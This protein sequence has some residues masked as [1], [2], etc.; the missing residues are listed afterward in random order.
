VTTDSTRSIV[1]LGDYD[2]DYPREKLLRR[3]FEEAG[4]TV[5]E[6]RFSE[7]SRFIGPAKLLLL[8]LFVVRIVRRMDEIRD[9]DNEIDALVLT[10]FNPL[11]LPIAA[12]YAWRLN[13]PLVYDLFV[14]LYRTA[15]LRNVHPVIVRGLALLERVTLSLPDYHLVGTNQFIDLYSDM[16][17]IPKGRFIRLPPGADEDWFYPREEIEKR[18]TFTVLYWGNFLPHHGVGTI[19][20]A[21][22]ELRGQ[23]YEFVF[24]GSGPKQKHYEEMADE[25]GLS[26]VRFEGFVPREDQQEWIA[27]SHVCLGI[28][29]DDPRSLASITN[30][31]SEAVASKKAVLTEAS[32]AIDEWFEHG[33][34]VYT[35]PSE[36]PVALAE[37]IEALADERKLIEQLESGG[38]EVYQR[39][40]DVDAIG[41]ILSE[42]LFAG[43]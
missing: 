14:S 35:V 22:A 13:C 4:A 21:A 29:A 41:E 8:P 40:F 37:A 27:S 20:G 6:C 2:Y 11:L 39:E 36:D 43:A 33:T 19:I 31:V 23:P 25:L 26:N 32:P 38:H 28:F 10:K 7:T 5:T 42:R 17:G 12:F 34:S 1:L 16:Y 18:E 3:G 30:K 15:E 24:L 9:S